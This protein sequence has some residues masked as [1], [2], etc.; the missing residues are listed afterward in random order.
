MCCTR[1]RREQEC[2]SGKE[3]AISGKECFIGEER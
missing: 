1:K 2:E 3:A